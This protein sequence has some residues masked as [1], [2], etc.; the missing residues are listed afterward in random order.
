LKYHTQSS[1]AKDSR[2]WNAT[3]TIN[4]SNGRENKKEKKQ[5]VEKKLNKSTKS[6]EEK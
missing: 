3:E 4:D 6:A 5:K 1:N 2:K